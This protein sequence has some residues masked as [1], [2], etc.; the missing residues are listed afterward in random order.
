MKKIFIDANIYLNFFDSNKPE[1]K[2][3]LDSLLEI[4][5]SLFIGSQIVN[6]VNRN[7]LDVAQRSLSNH[8]NNLSKI[9]PINLPEHLEMESTTLKKWNSQS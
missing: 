6:E 8:F 4:K 2:K 9:K 3:L 1:L 7:K 5:N